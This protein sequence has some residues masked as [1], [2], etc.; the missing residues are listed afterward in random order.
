MDFVF[1]FYKQQKE[2]H[3]NILKKNISKADCSKQALVVSNLIRLDKYNFEDDI[4]PAI[5]W[6]IN[7][8]FW[9]SNLYSLSSLRTKSKSNGL[10]KFQ[11]ILSKYLDENKT[12]KKSAL[13]PERKKSYDDWA[14]RED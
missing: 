5:L 4:K 14:D 7:D 13:S 3:P 12:N 11:N 1:G 2:N 8:S 10:T 6:A 9:T